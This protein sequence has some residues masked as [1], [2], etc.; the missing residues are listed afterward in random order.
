MRMQSTIARDGRPPRSP[1]GFATKEVLNGTRTRLSQQLTEPAQNAA[2]HDRSRGVAKVT[3]E[4]ESALRASGRQ[5]RVFTS[6]ND[7]VS[8]LRCRGH[9]TEYIL[10]SHGR[11]GRAK[12]SRKT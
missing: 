4:E 3:K 1:S 8:S 7:P 6:W 5:W 10:S 12:N 2:I 11:P 9:E